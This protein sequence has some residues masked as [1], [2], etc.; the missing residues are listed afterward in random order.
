M[1]DA[2]ADALPILRWI[3]GEIRR[4]REGLYARPGNEMTIDASFA[5]QWDATT[6]LDCPELGWRIIP[7]K[8]VGSGLRLDVI[9]SGGLHIRLRQGGERIRIAGRAHHQSLKKLFQA[10]SIPPWER[11]R[12]PLFFIDDQ[13]VQVGDR[14]S[15]ASF[16]ACKGEPGLQIILQRLDRPRG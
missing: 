4:W 16:A 5:A 7:H 10:S 6:T 12:L 3:G 13:L 14:W 9:R 8:V 1:L 15:D 2:R 11:E